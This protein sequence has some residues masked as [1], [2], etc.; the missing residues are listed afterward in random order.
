MIILARNMFRRRIQKTIL[1]YNIGRTYMTYGLI[2]YIYSNTL[3][4]LYLSVFTF[5]HELHNIF[6]VR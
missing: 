4:K 5:F 1:S 3:Q 2:I 6:N